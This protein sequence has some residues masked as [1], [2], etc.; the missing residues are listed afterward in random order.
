MLR[1]ALHRQG[2]SSQVSTR[3]HATACRGLTL[4]TA[5]QCRAWLSP[6]RIERTAFHRQAEGFPPGPQR[7]SF[8]PRRNP[9]KAGHKA[10]PGRPVRSCPAM[11]LRPAVSCDQ[12]GTPARSEVGS[13]YAAVGYLLDPR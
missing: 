4:A 9:M 6:N 7:P 2:Q 1:F 12:F 13:S 3:C 11:T 5:K 10:G 8:H